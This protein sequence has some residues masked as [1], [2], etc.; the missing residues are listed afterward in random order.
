MGQRSLRAKAQQLVLRIVIFTYTSSSPQLP[1][2]HAHSLGELEGI[3]LR[4]EAL[5][6]SSGLSADLG[7]HSLISPL[8]LLWI[9]SCENEFIEQ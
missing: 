3:W 9:R 8:C 6:Y 2:Q 4:E 7:F 5:R 1:L